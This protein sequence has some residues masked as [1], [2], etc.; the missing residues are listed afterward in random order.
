MAL[1]DAQMVARMK[2]TVGRRVTFELEPY[3]A[4]LR[5]GE[6]KA[7]EEAAARYGAFLGLD[8]ELV[9]RG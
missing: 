8:H 6:R 1:V 3:R 9:V 4:S 7:L 5:P 2:R